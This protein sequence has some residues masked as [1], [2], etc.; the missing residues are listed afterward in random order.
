[1]SD[2]L[3]IGLIGVAA[4]LAYCGGQIRTRAPVPGGAMAGADPKLMFDRTQAGCKV[5]DAPHAHVAVRADLA[6]GRRAPAKVM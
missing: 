5:V 1:M 3:H 6:A 4:T 2:P